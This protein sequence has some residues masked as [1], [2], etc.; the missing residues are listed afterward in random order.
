M[1]YFFII[2]IA[3]KVDT[4][5]TEAFRFDDMQ[6]LAELMIYTPKA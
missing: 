2:S 1:A 3:T 6:F 5:T 4:Y